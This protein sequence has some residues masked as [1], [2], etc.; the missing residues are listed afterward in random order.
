MKKIM[1]VLV[2][3][4]LCAVFAKGA[5]ASER[6]EFILDVSGSM[7]SL[8]G[9]EKKIAIARKALTAA[10]SETPDGSVAALRL[11][12]HR[13]PKT[14]KAESCKD[15]ELA[16]PFGPINKPQFLAA[17]NK[18]EPLGQT[19]IAY[20]LEL[21]GA[22]F[23]NPGDETA[24]IIVV[25]DGEE[26]CGGDPVAIAKALIAKGLKLKVHTI[27]FDVDPKTRAQ[28]EAL[29]AATGGKYRDARD[30]AGLLST[31][32]E[33][34]KESFLIQ[35]TK[36]AYGEPIKGGD[37]YDTA[38]P[39]ESGKLYRLTHHQRKNEFDYFVVDLLPGQ[40]LK[41]TVQTGE[42]GV[43]IDGEKTKDTQYAYAGLEIHDASHQ[44]VAGQVII[45][46]RNATKD[47]SFIA[48]TGQ[49]GKYYILIGN[50]YDNQHKDS[51]FKVEIKDHFD[52]GTKQDAPD[53]NKDAVPINEGELVGF[54]GPGDT[55]DVYQFNAAAGVNYEI[56][57][58][59]ENEKIQLRI[60]VT[61]SDGVVLVSQ[62]APNPGAAVH[63]GPVKTQKV[64]NIFIKIASPYSDIPTSDYHFSVTK[65]GAT[66]PVSAPTSAPFPALNVLPKDAP[67]VPAANPAP[68]ANADK[69]LQ[70]AQSLSAGASFVGKMKFYIIYS[71]AP[72]AAGLLIGFIWGFVKGRRHRA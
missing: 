52:A 59:P 61:D 17:L 31:L 72:L 18:A 32:K 14:Q 63:V 51:P 25:S 19:P 6:V 22:D 24:T 57:A 44:K 8:I 21:A 34:T 30:A 20:S 12:G 55:A 37:S 58:R 46:N 56:K 67:Q 7:N 26:T 62:D 42:S 68:A 3:F 23:G 41:A 4:C 71:V 43:E 27:G 16:I 13:I 10:I 15:S 45:G 28:L 64:G 49:G 54:L 47:M 70:P 48:G 50:T 9:A 29:A 39:I 33:L 36:T 5:V 2:S 53:T 35:K 66:T 65:T 1:I 69:S 60:S 38:V 40:E 11:Y